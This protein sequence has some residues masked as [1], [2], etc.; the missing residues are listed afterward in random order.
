MKKIEAKELAKEKSKI[1]IEYIMQ[2]LSDNEKVNSMMYFW[3]AKIDEE[4]MCTLDIYVPE[5]NFERHLNLGITVDHDLVLYERLL[6]DFLDV[7]LE[8]ETMGVTR[9]YFIKSMNNY[10]SGINV[11]NLSGSKIKVNFNTTSPDFM[12]LINEYNKRY[13]AFVQKNINNKQIK[14]K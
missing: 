7:F 11:V 12:N 13:N 4:K 5:K 1:V 14:L 6:N 2:I 10:F 8:H 3:Q 9:Y